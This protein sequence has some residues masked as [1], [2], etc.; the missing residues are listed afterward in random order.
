M[1]GNGSYIS[2]EGDGGPICDINV[3]P[4]VDICLVLLIIFMATAK[5]IATGGIEVDLPKTVSGDSSDS[6]L[7]VTIDQNLT[8]FVEY[9][10][11]RYTEINAA[12]KAIP[13]SKRHD[14]RAL[15]SADRRVPHGQIMEVIDTL[16]LGNVHRLA[17]AREPKEPQ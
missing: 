11:V 13:F 9:K 5:L 15:I 2:D 1:A 8:L 6:T 4:L 3:T 14:L 10:D 12:L 17:L 7:S 16:K